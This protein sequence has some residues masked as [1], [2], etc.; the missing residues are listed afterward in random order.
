[1]ETRTEWEK[2]YRRERKNKR[3]YKGASE[4]EK[5]TFDYNNVNHRLTVGDW[6]G[7]WSPPQI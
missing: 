3:K 5:G 1:M 7:K 4:K 2:L 6:L